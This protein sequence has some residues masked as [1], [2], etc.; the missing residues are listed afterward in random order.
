MGDQE[1]FEA[2]LATALRKHYGDTAKPAKL[3][4]LSGGASQELWSFS[5]KIGDLEQ[6]LILRRGMGGTDKASN[7]TAIPL[8]TEAAVLTAAGQNGVTCPQVRFVLDPDQDGMG[9]GYV[10]DAIAGETIARKIL[11]DEEY[12]AARKVLARDCGAAMAGIHSV[13]Q[14]KLPEMPVMDAATQLNAYR[15]IYDGFGDPHPVFE[16]AFRHLEERLPAN[17]DT[18]LLVHGDFRNGNIIVNEQGLAAIIDWELAHLGDPMED[19]GWICVTSWRFGQI[20]NPVGGFGQ[21]EEMFAGY[22]AAG[23]PKVDPARVHFWEVLGTLKWGIMCRIQMS[24]HVTGVARSV[25]RAAI[26]RRASET[27][28]DLL[29]LLSAPEQ[30]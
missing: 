5:T 18:P 23:G 30:A 17:P 9:A 11:R 16:L 13:P 22:E 27:E 8:A 15:E 12:A 26:G 3:T 1:E 24:A 29:A 7:S 28:I 21:R 6:P 19:L 2:K 10:M 4:R 25:E 14:D 20:D